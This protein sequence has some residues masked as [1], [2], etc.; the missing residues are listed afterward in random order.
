MGL[1]S[2]SE[3]KLRKATSETGLPLIRVMRHSNHL[4]FGWVREGDGHWH[5]DINP[6]T[7]K[8]DYE[9]GCGFSS[10]SQG[11]YGPSVLP[12]AEI[13][14]EYERRVQARR[15]EIERKNSE[16]AAFIEAY[17]E[18]TQTWVEAKAAEIEVVARVYSGN[19]TR[20][21]RA[22]GLLGPDEEVVFEWT[23]GEK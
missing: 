23:K 17:A 5:V 2:I 12:S 9:P 16:A 18:G 8:W 1:Q 15:E 10:C 22:A 6:F 3:R 21:L 13:V 14:A 4:W 7:W 19:L 11:T 20:D